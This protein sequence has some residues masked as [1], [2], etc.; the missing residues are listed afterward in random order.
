[1]ANYRSITQ[2]GTSEPFELQVAR[3]DITGHTALFKYGYNPLIINVEE[4]VWDAGG[5]YAYP[6]SAVK[7]TA[8]S[9]KPARRSSPGK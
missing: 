4:T 6:T 3:G 5:I 1:M 2:I 9:S 7:M 8:T